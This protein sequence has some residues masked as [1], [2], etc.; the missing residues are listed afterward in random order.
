[1]EKND[2]L[3]KNKTEENFS[4]LSSE[5]R[6]QALELARLIAKR[7]WILFVGGG[8]SRPSGLPLWSDLVRAMV[9]RLG[10]E[11]VESQD[12]LDVASLFEAN[13]G[14][15]ALVD[16]LR[17]NLQLPSASP[18]AL[19]NRLLDLRPPVIVTT[20]FDDLF[21]RALAQRETPYALVVTDSE[22]SLTEG[23]L[24]LLKPHGDLQ[25]P[26]SL[27]FTKRDYVRYPRQEFINMRL[28]SLAAQHSLFFVGYSLGD[29]DLEHQLQR[30]LDAQG[31]LARVHYLVIDKINPLRRKAIL[32]QRHIQALELGSYDHLERFLADLSTEAERIRQIEGTPRLFFPTRS[33]EAL[34]LSAADRALL[35]FLEEDYAPVI[36]AF[37]QL[38]FADAEK[39]LERIL[40][41]IQKVKEAQPL[42][43]GRPLDDFHQRVLLAR[44][45]VEGR[46]GH[47]EEAHAYFQQAE[48][49]RP[50]TGK[51]RLQA[52]E[53]LLI[54]GS[55]QEAEALLAESPE[56]QRGRGKE[57]LGLAALF[58]HEE[59]QFRA[60]F[61]DG[62]PENEEFNIVRA[63][64]AVET[65]DDA[66][67]ENAVEFLER[68]WKSSQDFPFGL[69][70]VATLTDKILRRIVAQG[71]EARGVDRKKL[72]QTARARYQQVLDIFEKQEDQY[73]EG[74]VSILSHLLDFHRILDERER[75]QEILERLQKLPVMTRERPFV[76]Y[77]AGKLPPALD[78][79]ETLF[80]KGYLSSCEKA[81]LFGATLL[82]EKNHTE[83]ERVY[84]QAL[85]SA[86]T[87]MD[88]RALS[89]A[90]LDV[91][92][93]GER[94]QEALAFLEESTKPGELFR[95][96]MHGMLLLSQKDREGALAVLRGALEQHPRSMAL[97]ENLVRLLGS[98]VETGDVADI[99]AVKEEDRKNVLAEILHYAEQLEAL[100]PSFEHKILRARLLGQQG[101]YRDALDI[102]EEVD[103]EGYVTLQTLRLRCE[104]LRNLGRNREVAELFARGQD[105][106]PDNYLLRFQE[107]IAWA[108]AGEIDRAATIWED[109]RNRPEANGDLYHNL[110][111]VYL[112]RGAL[113]PG[114]YSAAFDLVKEALEKFPDRQDFAPL[115]IQTAQGCGREK[116]A[117]EIIGQRPD[118]WKGPYL[119][120]VPNEK[121]IEFY[122]QERKALQELAALYR[123]GGIPFS[124]YA[125]QS[126]R[127]PLFLWQV[128]LHLWRKRREI[129]LLCSFPQGVTQIS[130]WTRDS[131]RGILLDMTALL[132]LGTLN[133]MREIVEALRRADVKVFLF[134]GARQWLEEEVGRLSLDQLP[135]YRERHKRLRDLLLASRERVEIHA[136][137]KRQENPL[138]EATHR[139][140]GHVVW[141][142]EIA[143]SCD[144]VYID[145]Y[146]P[147]E[148]RHELPQNIGLFSADLLTALQQ[149]GAV[150]P[151]E[152]QQIRTE[153]PEPFAKPITEVSIPLEKSMVLSALT[154]QAWFDAGLLDRWL[155]GEPGW[156]PKLIVGPVAWSQLEEDYT[157]D[158]IYKEALQVATN[159]RAFV[160]EAL[161]GGILEELPSLNP[162]DL[163]G[164]PEARPAFDSTLSLL[165]QARDR[166]LVL[167][168]DD[169]C[170][171]SLVDSR[172]P[173]LQDPA[174][175]DMATRARHAF[176]D[177]RIGGTEDVL[178]WLENT[179]HCPRERRLNLLWQVHRAGYR[180]LDMGEVFLWLLEQV[181]YNQ[182]ATPIVELLNDLKNAPSIKPPN[183]DAER[184]QLFTS[185]SL[186]GIL[187]QALRDLWLLDDVRLADEIRKEISA[188]LVHLFEEVALQ[189][190]RSTVAQHLFWKNLMSRMWLGNRQETIQGRKHRTTRLREFM[191]WV[192]EYILHDLDERRYIIREIEDLALYA[193][194]DLR[195]LLLQAREAEEQSFRILVIN[196]LEPV[197]SHGLL[198]EFNLIFRRL[199]GPVIGL[200]LE[201][202]QV[203][204]VQG[205]NGESFS[206][207]IPLTEMERQACEL[208]TQ[209]YVGQQ[210]KRLRGLAPFH[211]GILLER[212]V[213]A[214][215]TKDVDGQAL[216]LSIPEE[217]PLLFLPIVAEPSLRKRLFEHFRVC[218]EEVEP[219][220]ARLINELFSDLTAKD[221]VVSGKALR[222]LYGAY[223]LSVHFQLTRNIVGGFDYLAKLPLDELETLCGAIPSWPKEASFRELMDRQLS[224]SEALASKSEES[225][226]STLPIRLGPSELAL[227][228]ATLGEH[229]LQQHLQ[230]HPESQRAEVLALW[231][232]M[233]QTGIHIFEALRWLGVLLDQAYRY[234]ELKVF[235]GGQ[236][237]LLR[238][239]L[240]EHLLNILSDGLR[241]P[242]AEMPPE[243]VSLPNNQ[244]FRRSI[245][246]KVLCLAFQA[247]A[248]PIHR[249]A[250]SEVI[251]QQPDREIAGELILKSVVLAHRL[252]PVVLQ[253]TRL[254]LERIDRQLASAIQ[255]LRFPLLPDQFRPDLYGPE[256]DKYDH[257]LAGTLAVFRAGEENARIDDAIAGRASTPFWLTR[258]V[259]RA[260]LRLANQPENEAERQ[261]REAREQGIP[262]RLQTFLN[263]TPQ[264][265]AKELLRITSADL[266]KGEKL[267]LRGLA[268]LDELLQQA[269][270]SIKLQPE[271]TPP[272]AEGLDLVL[273]ATLVTGED[274]HLLMSAQTSAEPR[275]I[276]QS[277]VQLQTATR[278]F[279]VSYGIIIAPSIS[280]RARKICE[281]N[282]VGY[283]DLLGNA[284]VKFRGIFI[285]TAAS[286]KPVRK[287]GRPKSLFAPISTRVVRALLIDPPRHW[288]L[289]ELATAAHVSFGHIHKVKQELLNQEFIEVDQDKRFFLKD[290]SGLL[291]AWREA[292]I[293]EN[294]QGSSLFTLDKIPAIEE[295]IKQ[296]CDSKKLR[297]AFTLFSG[298]SKLAPFV[299]QNVV[300]FYFSGDKELLQKELN[301]KPVESGANVLLIAPYDEGVF[302]GLREIQGHTIVNPV[303]LYLDLFSYGGRGRE[304]AEFI[305]EKLLGF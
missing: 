61:P 20:N 158:E 143:R 128:R 15:N 252:L 38:R 145:D 83:A 236:E 25:R 225:S 262:N 265:Y 99:T 300:A 199:I 296:Y 87:P 263:R 233:A 247:M 72:L 276:R 156:P 257:L 139:Q 116:E 70:V 122:S 295:K 289:S 181:G 183:V 86:E 249:Q 104:L 81:L 90:L 27:V 213:D 107:A 241:K 164:H 45:S 58:R 272:D 256:L 73:P 59:A 79:I 216:R 7:D 303:Q 269:S 63:H 21:E 245:N 176:G 78:V 166:G 33:V 235:V 222:N 207:S 75:Q 160:V 144:A 57:I 189:E 131:Q 287:P 108:H 290:P 214:S 120:A 174:L 297:Y 194:H 238:E 286:K 50:F 151:N 9:K 152:A 136:E 192:A 24:Q 46:K 118:L 206:E 305:R 293:F 113:D 274:C 96:L 244:F 168:T 34:D 47:Y 125:S 140:L 288:K 127:S 64:L 67:V 18:N 191:G 173:L 175:M 41:A 98:Q 69:L 109:L 280:E 103:R 11:K 182:T 115:L 203:F 54:F 133:V 68:A 167:W 40:K 117:W 3:A 165:Q 170:A 253:D 273:K 198:R 6:L 258:Q 283:V 291:N 119:R 281:E 224:K 196:L 76:E 94:Y 146:L 204:E 208:L 237:Q 157:E 37:D 111:L 53:V 84:R 77:L 162:P 124:A 217:M 55:F 243:K 250:W 148:R 299:R 264:E 49:L 85:A 212:T 43:Q 209:V 254:S 271:A 251:K 130:L 35:E 66:T 227:S 137:V 106:Y 4:Y 282:G 266:P 232:E 2:N 5:D 29:P 138:E 187:S 163:G 32:Q 60:L 132:T 97:L 135:Y 28:C 220:L 292:Y 184:F 71:W 16:F 51:R 285:K 102:V 304:Q 261:I 56:G 275:R 221:Q 172:G 298:A 178:H 30:V 277:L 193:L 82:E 65:A 93:K 242:R 17:T 14:R 230:Q 223:L 48:G 26:D 10:S 13:L 248:S 91:L 294:S 142:V 234:P 1:M 105:R 114:A 201:L 126:P 279:P 215:I 100:L 31:E 239:W 36:E 74:L 302:L 195:P 186:S 159:L 228:F 121:V 42:N 267:L 161:D 219:P 246:A 185:L 150:L 188:E 284:F 255:T 231:A 229:L 23:R 169:F 240:V 39:H 260:L 226:S 123:A 129:P 270:A 62:C 202:S 110:V 259:R 179:G 200:D 197:F 210:S 92:L 19:H 112:Q 177:V 149:A 80:Q 153:H 190:R 101:C 278:V 134:A 268:R 155:Q 8:I 205:P 180:F 171:R 211:M 12:P 89:E 44:A 147:P 154:L 22:L 52:A 141:D 88:R 95:E 218:F 301:L